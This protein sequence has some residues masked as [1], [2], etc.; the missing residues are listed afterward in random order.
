MQKLPEQSLTESD[1][2]N[3]QKSILESWS[4]CKTRGLDR[5]GPHLPPVLR[6]DEIE[7][8]IRSNRAYIDI[9]VRTLDATFGNLRDQSIGWGVLDADGITLH[10]NTNDQHFFDRL[11]SLNLWKG[12]HLAEEKVGTTAPTLA[13]RDGATHK[14]AGHEHFCALYSCFSSVA[15][16]IRDR[17][18]K[19]LGAIDC[20]SLYRKYSS[21]E[22]L[23]YLSSLL[24]RAASA[25]E[26]E[27]RFAEDLST[28]CEAVSHPRIASQL[29]T[30]GI[31]ITN[32]EGI[33]IFC[34]PAVESFTGLKMIDVIGRDVGAVFPQIRTDTAAAPGQS[35]PRVFRV[36]GHNREE[37]PP[38]RCSPIYDSLGNISGTSI[39]VHPAKQIPDGGIQRDGHVAGYTF[40]DIVGDSQAIQQSIRWAKTS[41][42]HSF[43][44]LLEGET[45]T[46]KELFANAIHNSSSRS[47]G[48]FVA[49]NCSAIPRD[50]VESELFG[51]VGGAFTGSRKEGSRGKF[52]IADGGTL[53]L[54]EIN[55]LPVEIQAKLLRFLESGEVIR[56][57]EAKVHKVDAR[58][59]ACTSAR[60]EEGVER[61][62]FR[63]DLY[64]RLNV[65]RI[66]IPP[67]RER[68]EDI[69]SLANHILN[70][71]SG[72][73]AD[74]ESP[75]DPGV[76]AILLA[77]DWPG[78]VRELRNCLKHAVA[79]AGRRE[80]QPG[81]LPAYLQGNARPPCAD[82]QPE[83]PFLKMEKEL[84]LYALEET[85]GL[86]EEAAR[87]LGISRAT[88]YRKMKKHN[89]PR[90]RS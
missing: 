68:K 53:L 52:Q 38:I 5:S 6:A 76:S 70:E 25:I 17:T 28:L 80:I 3:F 60:L 15:S 59:I 79:M 67:L 16:P 44:V 13:I 1:V 56:V 49:I 62:T 86:R 55:S 69:V 29:S 83:K 2:K 33:V 64:Y 23:D 45:G 11:R 22:T 57:G 32:R 36:K 66:R 74:L 54:D 84:L 9:A 31:L 4:R 46:G 37:C 63:S 18:G 34:S 43:T 88:I 90:K 50:I 65:L 40:E 72:T 24:L 14:V 87:L 58:V 61:G 47:G 10:A 26:T 73:R 89:L 20:S 19:I 30:T 12:S 7:A 51:Y 35:C 48:P 27:L 21:E 39:V 41:S 81:D 8:R 75:P 77:H 42:R 85:Q 82:V 78:N 71:L